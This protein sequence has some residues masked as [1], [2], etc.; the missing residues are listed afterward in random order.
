M[1]RSILR[2]IRA[3]IGP[4][5]DYA[6]FDNQLIM[7]INSVLAILRQIGI[8]NET[9]SITGETETW[10]DL[11]DTEDDIDIEEVK[12]Y[13][14]LRVRMLFDPPQSGTV[15]KHFEEEIKEH[16]WR[17]NIEGDDW[18]DIWGVE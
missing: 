14:A 2:S 17:L 11:F 8:G 15:A 18:P 4:S 12:I 9:F 10:D 6:A 1:E 13:I 7:Y 16:E 3:L 5:A